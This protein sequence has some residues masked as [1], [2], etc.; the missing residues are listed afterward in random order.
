M[1]RRGL[2]AGTST[3][4]EVGRPVL[5]RAAQTFSLGLTPFFLDDD[6]VVIEPLRSAFSEAMGGPVDL[7]RCIP[8]CFIRRST[9]QRATSKPSRFS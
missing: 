5:V 1:N 6:A 7:V 2:L 8:I 4:A 9:V 3:I